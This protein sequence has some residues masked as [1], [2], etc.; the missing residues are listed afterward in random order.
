MV[1]DEDDGLVTVRGSVASLLELTSILH[2][3]LL[4]KLLL[5]MDWVDAEDVEEMQVEAED[6]DRMARQWMTGRTSRQ[7]SG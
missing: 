5:V 2:F 3:S 6:H 7:N 1:E 4:E